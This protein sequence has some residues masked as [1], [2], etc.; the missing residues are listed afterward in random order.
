MKKMFYFSPFTIL[1]NIILVESGSLYP[2]QN[3][4]HTLY[5]RSSCISLM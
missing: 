2:S 4:N 5:R 1:S 3:K